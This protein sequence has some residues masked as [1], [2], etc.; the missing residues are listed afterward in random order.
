MN[1]PLSTA[2]LFCLFSMSNTLSAAALPD[3]FNA[4]YVARKA[5]MTLGQV[6]V[7]LRYHDNQYRYE[8]RTV[9]KGLLSIFRKDI[10]TEV[11]T[12]NVQK[13]RLILNT[14]DYHLAR[15]KKSRR[16]SINIK[17]NKASGQHRGQNYELIVPTGILDRASIEIVLMRDAAANPLT[18]ISYH[19]VDKGVLKTYTFEQAGNRKVKVPAGKFECTEYRRGHQSDK[20]AT[21]LCL[22]PKLDY[23][24]VYIT[25]SEK[26]TKFFMELVSYHPL[27]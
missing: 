14:Y 26:G 17:G 15:K 4:V 27:P 25:H 20:R 8:K 7:S 3:A 18:P 23:L 24:P 9:T 19:I 22:A 13:D 2:L 5:G 10:I 1:K 21:A 12:G 11:S 6:N 16:T